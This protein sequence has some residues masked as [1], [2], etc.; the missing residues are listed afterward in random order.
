[1]DRLVAEARRCL[2]CERNEKVGASFEKFIAGRFSRIDLCI[3]SMNTYIQYIE[4]EPNQFAIVS[5]SDADRGCTRSG[6]GTR[7]GACREVNLIRTLTK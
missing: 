4:F 1:M 7:E 6:R 2:L 3:L 5:A